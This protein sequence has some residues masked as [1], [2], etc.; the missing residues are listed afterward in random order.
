MVQTITLYAFSA[1][2]IAFFAYYRFDAPP[3]LPRSNTTMVRY[4]LAYAIYAVSL[5]GLAFMVSVIIESHPSALRALLSLGVGKDQSKSIPVDLLTLPAPL[6][7]AFL[8]SSLL[9]NLPFLRQLDTS[10]H[11]IARRFGAIPQNAR[12]LS[13]K[14]K[15]AEWQ[16][17]L[18][19]HT[20]VVR[21]L[22]NSELNPQHFLEAAAD[23]RE[24]KWCQITSL[25]LQ[26]R[27]IAEERAVGLTGQ[28]PS[29]PRATSAFVRHREVEYRATNISYERL[30]RLAPMAFDP[31]DPVDPHTVKIQSLFD[32]DSKQLFQS[33]RDLISC[34]VLRTAP[35]FGSAMRAV[36]SWGFRDLGANP[37]V[38]FHELAAIFMF[39]T[40]LFF[41]SYLVTYTLRPTAEEF[42]VA[43]RIALSVQIAL[44]SAIAAGAAVW[45]KGVVHKHTG[46]GSGSERAYGF[47]LIAAGLAF[48][49]WVVIRSVRVMLIPDQSATATVQNAATATAQGSATAV[50]HPSLI[51]VWH[52]LGPAIP[53]ALGP[54]AIAIVV[55]FLLD[56]RTSTWTS[57]GR[58]MDAKVVGLLEGVGCAICLALIAIVVTFVR[59]PGVWNDQVLLPLLIRRIPTELAL[60][61]VIG[62]MVP[63]AH[64]RSL[65]KKQQIREEIARA[66]MEVAGLHGLAPSVSD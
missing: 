1:I 57:G 38:P 34:G 44:T 37:D 8:F 39:G 62:Y 60:G 59:H 5:L 7:S 61:F 17:P 29:E 11:N 2:C 48:C 14:L 41:V 50:V 65:H 42:H 26:L 43:F 31:A 19:R 12:V 24:H 22:H 35:N 46:S 18:E 27:D 6:I 54:I 53:W 55:S 10:L 20:E 4:W 33:Q 21:E 28:G 51:D 23:S 25:M 36:A 56:N 45:V 47:Y 66:D 3:G 49:G 58:P 40:A 16:V 52:S 30:K 9:P 63:A 64:R 15:N 32:N 13:A